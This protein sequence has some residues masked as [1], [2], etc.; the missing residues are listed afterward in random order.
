MRRP[1]PFAMH[2]PEG[3]ADACTLQQR[4]S[5]ASHFLA[6]GTDLVIAVKEQGLDPRVGVVAGDDIM[7]RLVAWQA[8]GVDL[9][10]MDDGRPF[11]E[12]ADNSSYTEMAL[13]VF[14]RT[15][16]SEMPDFIL[17][18]DETANVIS[19]ILSMKNQSE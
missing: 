10:N 16:H 1:V 8:E 18:E 5:G 4:L 12:I 3:L 17:T 7:D 14:L 19:Y 13:R 6:G 9:S 11:A 15:P 2:Q